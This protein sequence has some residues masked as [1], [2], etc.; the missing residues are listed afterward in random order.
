MQTFRLMSEVAADSSAELS[1]VRTASP[2]LHG[3]VALMLLLVAT[4]LAV[5]KPRGLTPYGQRKLRERH[6]AAGL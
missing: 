3:V 4:V 1:A 5:F 6:T 2:V